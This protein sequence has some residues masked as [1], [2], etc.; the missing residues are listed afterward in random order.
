MASI[1]EDLSEALVVVSSVSASSDA[2]QATL[3]RSVVQ[4]S[5]D[6]LTTVLTVLEKWYQVQRMWRMVDTLLATTDLARVRCVRARDAI[7]LCH[8]CVGAPGSACGGRK[9]CW[10]G[11]GLQEADGTPGVHR[12]ARV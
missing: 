3:L 10:H 12:V 9:I 11:Q 7:A 4:R 5:R 1:K 6:T 8:E 2:A